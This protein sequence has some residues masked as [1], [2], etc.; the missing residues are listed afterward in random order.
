MTSQHG[1]EH[2]STRGLPETWSRV[3]GPPPRP[4]RGLSAGSAGG[5]VPSPRWWPRRCHTVPGPEG[6]QEVGGE[7]RKACDQFIAFI[8]SSLEP[9]PQHRHS[10][11]RGTH[12]SRDSSPAALFMHVRVSEGSW[13]RHSILR[14]VFLNPHCSLGCSGTGKSR[15][16][17]QTSGS[18]GLGTDCLMG[19]GCPSRVMGMF[20]NQRVVVAQH[21]EWTKCH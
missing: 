7:S 13:G 8:N 6:E 11:S 17:T 18:Q 19:T 1:E 10:V 3:P 14:G 12:G 16:R 15:D 21:W 9:Q 2:N 20:W 5:P 4:R